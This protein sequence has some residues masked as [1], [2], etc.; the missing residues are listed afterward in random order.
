MQTICGLHESVH[1]GRMFGAESSLRVYLA[2]ETPNRI[3]HCI[4]LHR[5]ARVFWDGYFLKKCPE[6]DVLQRAPNFMCRARFSG[7]ELDYIMGFHR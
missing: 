1:F 6:E 3:V 4:G 2:R 7:K 5:L